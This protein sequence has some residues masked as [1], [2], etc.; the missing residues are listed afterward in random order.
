MLNYLSRLI[1]AVALLLAVVAASAGHAAPS[2]APFVVRIDPARTLT[3]NGPFLG[4]GAQ[5]DS[6]LLWSG[7]NRRAG[8]EVPGDFDQIVAPRL[9]ALRL[10]VVRKFIDMSWY[11]P[12]PGRYTWDSPAM[13]ALYRNLTAHQHNGTQVM[14]TI[15]VIPPW[16]SD[17]PAD[18]RDT[19]LRPALA[20]PSPAYEQDWADAV[21]ALVRHLYGLDGSGLSFTNVAYLGAPNELAGI[22]TARLVRPFTMLREGLRAAGLAER[23][24]LFGPDAFVEELPMAIGE[25]GL[26]PLLGLYDFHYYAAAPIEAGLV[27]AMDRLAKA[28]APTGK[29]LWLTE[30]GEI[31]RKNDDWRTLPLTAIAAMNHGL[32]AALVWNVQDQIYNTAN[33]PAWG[34]WGVYDTGYRLKPAAYAWALMAGHLPPAAAVY[35]HGCAR[36]QCAG[37]RLAALG[38]GA[39]QRA[40]IAYSLADGPTRL[41][42]DLGA[43]A[44]TLPLY[45][46]LLD[47]AAPPDPARAGL[48]LGYD[49][50][51]PLQGGAFE[52]T[53]PAGALAVYSTYRPIHPPSLATGRPATAS[54][55]E[56]AAY[57]AGNATDNDPLTRWSS[58]FSDPQTITVDLGQRR[59][60]QTVEIQWE[61]AYARAYQVQLS[62]DGRRWR[63][64]ADVSQGQ[65]GVVVHRF[66]A[67]QARYVRLLGLARATRYGYSLFEI[68]VR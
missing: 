65:G 43:A 31:T 23:V 46:Y 40:V 49:R 42:V 29:Q 1:A 7:P 61:A 60:V 11:L 17:R 54:S 8:A 37:L 51:I 56:G 18:T 26:D 66:G 38:D 21:L 45:R 64:V 15:W 50:A 22:T 57:A 36:E 25:P 27:A 52:D 13:Q 12:E 24:T 2:S 3:V 19:E 10:P 5:D 39:G 68:A 34:L 63:T 6:N 58:A 48:L 55:E 35:D 53:L 28:T 44:P 32:A 9:R 33:M 67:A 59:Q 47:P 20:F 4:L 30:F 41:R 14:L 62:D 16:L